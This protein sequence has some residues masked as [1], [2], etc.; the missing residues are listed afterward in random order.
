MSP[1]WVNSWT[2]LIDI[3]SGRERKDTRATR[4]LVARSCGM[5][6]TVE[7]EMKYDAMQRNEM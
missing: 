2:G 4:Y 6:K 3:Y 5:T 7:V 1:R